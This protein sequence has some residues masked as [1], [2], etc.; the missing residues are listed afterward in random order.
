[1]S[2]FIDLCPSKYFFKKNFK[3]LIVNSPKII[4]FKNSSYILF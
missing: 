1:M 2:A 3:S 4:N